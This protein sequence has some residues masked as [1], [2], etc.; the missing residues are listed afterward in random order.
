MSREH[1]PKPGAHWEQQPTVREVLV[2]DGGPQPAEPRNRRQRRAADRANRANR[3][4]GQH[5]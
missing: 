5:R 4:K 1:T 2:P 3:Q